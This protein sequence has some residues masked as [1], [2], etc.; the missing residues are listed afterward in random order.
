MT[1]TAASLMKEK[2]IAG[3]IINIASVVGM[4]SIASLYISEKVEDSEGHFGALGGP[5]LEKISGRIRIRSASNWKVGFGFTS[6]WK[7]GPGSGSASKCENQD[8][9]VPQHWM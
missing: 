4:P 6:Y 5:N 7:V 1:Q 8:P 9:A 3:S 2:S